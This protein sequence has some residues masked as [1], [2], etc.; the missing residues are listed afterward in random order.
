MVP[1]HLLVTKQGKGRREP[2]KS[3]KISE[4]AGSEINS[5]FLNHSGKNKQQQGKLEHLLYAGSYVKHTA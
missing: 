3:G 2:K 1:Y 5:C 4:V